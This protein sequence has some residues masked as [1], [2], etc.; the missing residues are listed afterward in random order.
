MNMYLYDYTHIHIYICVCEIYIC[1]WIQQVV[2]TAGTAGLS[3]RHEVAVSYSDKL[4]GT[5]CTH[6]YMYVYDMNMQMCVNVCTCTHIRK[7]IWLSRGYGVAT[8][9]SS[10]AR[11]VHICVCIYICVLI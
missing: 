10:V 7:C 2:V 9:T 5:V 4:C 11:Y 6:T 1:M 3:R 8:R